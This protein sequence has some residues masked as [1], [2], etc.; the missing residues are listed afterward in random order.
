MLACI[1]RYF[2]CRQ[3]SNESPLLNIS[4]DDANV[5]NTETYIPKITYGKVIKVY[6]GDT[7][8]VA[9]YLPESNKQVY[10]FSIRLRGID[11]PELRGSSVTE[12][13]HAVIARDALSKRILDQYVNIKNVST[14]KYGRL[15]ADVYF[16]E[17][18]MNDWMVSNNYAVK[19][20]GGTK[21]R[22]KSWDK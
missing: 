22:D 2:L 18:N 8:T 14:E 4:L 10:K 3:S 6:D 12:K 16:E 9:A 20:D 5:H 13:K 17:T 19:Y 21:H 7:I 11:S 1:Q 15:L